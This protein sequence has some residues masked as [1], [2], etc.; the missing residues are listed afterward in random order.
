M[1]SDDIIDDLFGNRKLATIF[2]T[3]I[4]LV[5]L[6]FSFQRNNGF[7]LGSFLMAITFPPIYI[8]YYLATNKTKVF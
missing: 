1:S 6:Y 2:W 5:A 8:V 3:A 4:T 7:E